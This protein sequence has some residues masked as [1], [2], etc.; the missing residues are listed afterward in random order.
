MLSSLYVSTPSHTSWPAVLA[1]TLVRYQVKYKKN[2]VCQTG[3]DPGY[4]K[5]EGPRSKR[6][7]GWPI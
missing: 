1:V 3:A 5:R 2:I 6:G 7:A 4:V